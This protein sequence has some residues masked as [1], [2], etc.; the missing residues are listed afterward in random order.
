VNGTAS[1]KIEVLRLRLE[2][3]H[4]RFLRD[5][6]REVNFVWSYRNDLQMF[7]RERAAS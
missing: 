3:R 5:L 1:T 2:D 7:N 4:A 6:A